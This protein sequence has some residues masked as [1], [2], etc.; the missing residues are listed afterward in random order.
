MPSIQNLISRNNS[1]VVRRSDSHIVVR[2]GDDDGGDMLN[3]M[4]VVLALIFFALLLISTLFLMRRM[5]RQ[6]KMQEQM[7]PTYQE[8]KSVR[9]HHNLTIQTSQDGRSSV[10]YIGGE[11]GRSPMLQNPASAPHSPDNVPE[12][13][14]TFPDEQD[15]GGRRKS[16]RVLVVRVGDGGSVGLEPVREELPAYEKDSKSQFYSVDMD[17]I[18]GLREKERFN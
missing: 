17:S 2:R 3:L 8:V 14:I 1:P 6:Q 9:N 15:E 4:I 16:G 18:G 11:N 5:R 10:L 12:I 13:H 7:L